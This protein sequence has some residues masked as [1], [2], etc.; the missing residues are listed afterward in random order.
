[1]KEKYIE[2]D[3][4]GNY[5]SHAATA[6]S[7]DTEF[8]TLSN[9]DQ[10][11]YRLQQYGLN[12]FFAAAAAKAVPEPETIEKV[13][14]GFSGIK[15]WFADL[16]SKGFLGQIKNFL[17]SIFQTVGKVLAPVFNLIRKGLKALMN[18]FTKIKNS[19]FVRNTANTLNQNK[20]LGFP[21]MNWIQ[22]GLISAF[23]ITIFV[24]LYNRFK[25]REDVE[26][27]AESI[28]MD[29]DLLREQDELGGFAGKV[30]DSGTKNANKFMEDGKDKEKGI[31]SKVIKGLIL[32]FAVFLVY[33]KFKGGAEPRDYG[34]HSATAGLATN[35][36]GGHSATAG[37][38]I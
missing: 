4:E 38:E 32:V 28:G 23:F 35:D 13:K 26:K 24:K 36:Y 16:F 21:I 37:L 10:E 25:S 3:G 2:K 17:A 15:D 9:S 27:C 22:F 1:M 11:Y 14:T 34:G 33:I 7:F 19:D 8:N 31:L 12:S 6:G 18:L 30:V 29:L 5:D 20:I